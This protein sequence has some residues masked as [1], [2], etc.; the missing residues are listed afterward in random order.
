MNTAATP[1]SLVS[2]LRLET[3]EG[4]WQISTSAGHISFSLKRK[5]LCDLSMRLRVTALQKKD[6]S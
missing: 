1:A 3:N 2:H 5:L 4:E 6:V